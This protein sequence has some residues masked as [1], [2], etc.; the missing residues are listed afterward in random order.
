MRLIKTTINKLGLKIG[1][2]VTLQLINSVGDIFM[3]SSGYSLDKKINIIS[4]TLEFSIMETD[5]IDTIS[6][7]KLTLPSSNYFV[8][9]IMSSTSTNPHELT[10][11]FKIG[12]Y[13]GVLNISNSKVTLLDTFAEKLNLYF[14]QKINN[15]TQTEMDIV[16]LYIYYADE[17]MQSNMT[18]DVSQMMDSYLFNLKEKE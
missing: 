18:I 17:I 7:Y 13:D 11:L 1:D 16:N 5:K 4:D 10:S 3:T 9:T 14:L 8:F 15:F 6:T 2:T 12:C